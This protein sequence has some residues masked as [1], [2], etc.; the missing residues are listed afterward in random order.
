MYGHVY[1]SDSNS[2]GNGDCLWLSVSSGVTIRDN[3]I[4]LRCGHDN[5]HAD[6]L[7]LA[8][9]LGGHQ[10]YRNLFEV[11]LTSFYDN[12]SCVM[13]S[14]ND[15]ATGPAAQSNIHQNVFYMPYGKSGVVWLNASNMVFENN[16]VYSGDRNAACVI[17]YGEGDNVTVRNNILWKTVSGGQMVLWNNNATGLTLNGNQY[18][19]GS[20]T[21]VNIVKVN[22]TYY[23]LSKLK[24]AG[25]ENDGQEGNP[26]FVN[27]PKDFHLTLNS[28]CIDKGLDLGYTSDY[29][30]VSIPKGSGYDIGAFEF[31]H[32]ISSPKNLTILSP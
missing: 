12:T 8:F 22:S 4:Y 23:T 17:L 32:T 31:V 27:A 5:P 2:G 24:S 6:C 19:H 21:G 14:D 20:I 29:D 28:P 16:T 18:Y 10:I 13:W 15:A 30:M 11:L 3:A 26:L 25:Y 9:D 1:D 7:Q